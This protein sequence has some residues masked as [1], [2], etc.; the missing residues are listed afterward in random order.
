MNDVIEAVRKAGARLR[1]IYDENARPGG[2]ADMYRAGVSLEQDTVDA[3][4]AA[5]DPDAHWIA[6]A[7][8]SRVQPPGD[9][10]VADGV[11]GAVNLVHGLPEWAVTVTLIRDNVPAMTVVHQPV[12]DLTWTAVRGEG[13]YRNGVR[14]RVSGK[15][16]LDAAIVTASQA[17][18]DPVVNQRFGAALAAMMGRALFVRNT[19][20]T[21]FP[22]LAVAEGHYDAF[23][24]YEPD[25][26]GVAA[27][28][29]LVTE[30][31]GVATDLAGGQWRPGA[32]DV[33][34]AA[35]GVH[36]AAL[37]VLHR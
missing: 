20:P 24:Q 13:A 18:G 6:D 17:G 21:T 22:L 27:G 4:R 25:L 37:E 8:E 15:T 2:R 11:E 7:D 12:G 30:A 29:L 32:A 34:I 28:S 19:V 14:L 5:L 1:D 31:G 35:P 36:A 33:L 10:W 16:E 3:L 9:W 26:P 23:W